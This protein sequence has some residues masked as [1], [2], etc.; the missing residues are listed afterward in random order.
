[1][2]KYEVRDLTQFRENWTN[3]VTDSSHVLL[4]SWFHLLPA[5]WD[6]FSQPLHEANQTL[7]KDTILSILDVLLVNFS[8]SKIFYVG[9]KL[10]TAVAQSTN[11]ETQPPVPS[12]I[13]QVHAIASETLDLYLSR[14]ADKFVV[15]EELS[16]PSWPW[17]TNN[18]T[19]ITVNH[20]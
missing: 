2:W 3:V 16:L 13:N 1:M 19:V 18:V 20:K 9:P 12:T 17:M 6:I 15:D 7:L 5:D 8:G 14:Y 11:S 4:L 10:A